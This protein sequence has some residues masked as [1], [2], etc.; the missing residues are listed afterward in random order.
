MIQISMKVDWM[1]GAARRHS[2]GFTLIELMVTLAVLAVLIGIAVPS[3]T[4]VTLG[5]KLRGQ[6]N[7]LAAGAALARSEAVKRNQSVT[8]CAS[9]NGTTCAS[10]GGWQQGWIV[11]SSGGT[12]VQAH[13]AAPSGFIIV[14]TGADDAH[15]ISFLPTGLASAAMELKI[16]RSS[17]EAGDQERLVRISMTGR[18][19]VSKTTTGDCS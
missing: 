18:T 19:Y 11:R 1:D 16:C 12:V 10:S 14:D 15:S 2:S 8:L 13:S 17:P 5:S 9:S 6:A 3:F 4:D 7:D